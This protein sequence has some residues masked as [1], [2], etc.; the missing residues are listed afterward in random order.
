MTYS[1]DRNRLLLITALAAAGVLTVLATSLAASPPADALKYKGVTRD[2]WVFNQEL[3]NVDDNKTGLP[4]DVFNPETI[5]TK[6]GDTVNIHFFNVETNADDQHSF[7]I[8]D[9]PYNKVDKVLKGGENG[10]I[11]FVATK[12]GVFTYECK[13]HQPTMRGQ[14]VVEA[15]TL[16][17]LKR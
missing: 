16:D 4:A 13:V 2:F 1:V 9:K 6:K 5:V 17:E 3:N 14:L 7:T 10:D 8:Y 15:P 12:T 11:S